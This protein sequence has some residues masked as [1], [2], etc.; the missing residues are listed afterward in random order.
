MSKEL[1]K[2]LIQALMDPDDYKDQ[3][4]PIEVDEVLSS[5]LNRCAT[6]MA[7]ITFNDEDMQLGSTDHNRP[8]YVTG[9]IG[10]KRINRILLDCGSAVNLPPLRVFRAMGIK[11]NQLSRLCSQYRNL[12]KW[13]KKPY[14]Q[15]L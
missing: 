5:L 4:D 15:L 10:D 2:A 3:V 8:L 13:G 9:I 14:A 7:C 6:C 1:R 11:P 12:I